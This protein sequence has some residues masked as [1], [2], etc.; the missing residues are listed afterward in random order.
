M[1]ISIPFRLP[2]AVSR[3]KNDNIW[4]KVDQI[5]ELAANAN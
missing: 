4:Y 2:S 5:C 3:H 1:H